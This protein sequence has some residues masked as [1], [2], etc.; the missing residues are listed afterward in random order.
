MISFHDIVR[1]T[2][3]TL[4]GQSYSLADDSGNPIIGFKSL[5]KAEYKSAGKTV[6]EP[7]EE[8]SFATYNKTTEPREF[9][10]D[11]AVQYPNQDFGAVLNT[12]EELKRGTDV[13]TFTTPFVSYS[14]LT[15]EGYSTVFESSTSMLIVSLQC[16]EVIEVSQGYTNVTINDATPIG[17]AKDPSNDDTSDTG[18]TGTRGG[19]EE[20][21]KKTKESVLGGIIPDET[22]EQ[23]GGG[24]GGF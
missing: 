3:N 14:D 1:R 11:L 21:K 15:L 2:S 8:N 19:T 16:K 13:F 4:F 18:M 5:L 24:G 6:F 12:L 22:E 17:D 10:F 9:A 7:I 20:E 23:E